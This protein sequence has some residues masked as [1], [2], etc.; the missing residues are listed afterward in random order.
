MDLIERRPRTQNNEGDSGRSINLALSRR[1]IEALTAAGMLEAVQPL[2]IPMKGRMLHL[3]SGESVFS[4]YG[5]RPEEVIY[6][7]SRRRLNQLLVDR[8]VE[9]EAVNVVFGHKCTSIDFDAANITLED[10]ETGQVESRDFGLL[11]G[12]DGAGS[13]V[14]QGLMEQV[15]GTSTSEFLDHD[16]KELEIPAGEDGGW[17]LEKEAL[18]IWPREDYMLIALPNLDG[19]FTVTLFLPKRRRP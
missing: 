14:R 3:E 11:I 7:I 9:A 17:Q 1:G 5:Q 6:S 4:S 13:R 16:Y 15:E 12:A 19:S 2:L 18:H 8:A 10:E